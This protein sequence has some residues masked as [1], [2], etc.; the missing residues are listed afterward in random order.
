[1]P[2]IE[3]TALTKRYGED[4]LAVDDLD[5]TVEKGE[6]FGFLGPNGAGKSTTINMLLDFVRPTSGSATVLGYD[7][8]DDPGAIRDRIGVLPEGATLY[9]R[10]TAR[11]HVEWV[12]DTKGVDL[13]VDATLERVGILADADRPAGGFSK[14]M[15]QRL[16]LGMALVGDPDLLVL[17]EP[18]SGL[19]PTGIQEMRELLRTEADDGTTVFF[20]SHILSEVEAICDRV[21]I[22]NAGRLVALDSIEALR[23][24]AADGATIELELATALDPDG[25]DL[26]SVDGVSRSA[27]DGRTVTAV[28]EDPTVKVDVVRRLDERATVTDI[29]STDTS[30][31]EL[32]NRYTDGTGSSGPRQSADESGPIEREVTA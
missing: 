26:E 19:D 32:F 16:G 30:L 25:L 29:R 22:M 17:D 7:A 5:L 24:E 13:D 12:A 20:S 21:G 31:E 4:V 28:C 1:M 15:R 14:G 8:Q 10:L 18:S 2:A 11:E 6:I 23:E 27:V 3:T 9:E